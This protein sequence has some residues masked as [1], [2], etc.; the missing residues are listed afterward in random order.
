MNS[1]IKI[2]KAS[3]I[4]KNVTELNVTYGREIK[5]WIAVEGHFGLA[6]TSINILIKCLNFY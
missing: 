3:D 4:E 6:G 2:V 5:S 1:E